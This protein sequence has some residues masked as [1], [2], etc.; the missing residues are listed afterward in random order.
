M[1]DQVVEAERVGD[2]AHASRTIT[3]AHQ[4]QQPNQVDSDDK[5]DKENISST[6]PAP[7][8][9]RI[10]REQTG[11]EWQTVLDVAKFGEELRNKQNKA[12]VGEMTWPEQPLFSRS[13]LNATCRP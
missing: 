6:R 12:V 13:V 9:K 1:D 11:T 5:S 3:A 7:V 10:R 4:S 2:E 8:A